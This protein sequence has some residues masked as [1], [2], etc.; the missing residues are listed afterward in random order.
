MIDDVAAA[1][2]AVLRNAAG[3][4]EVICCTR[5]SIPRMFERGPSPSVFLAARVSEAAQSV[6]RFGFRENRV[7]PSG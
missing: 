4:A 1:A 5:K 6:I 3:R 2:A 7:R